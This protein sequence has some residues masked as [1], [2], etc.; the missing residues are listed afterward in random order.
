MQHGTQAPFLCVSYLTKQIGAATTGLNR[1]NCFDCSDRVSSWQ[2]VKEP[3]Y[4]VVFYV[5]LFFVVW[6][7]KRKKVMQ[8]GFEINCFAWGYCKGWNNYRYVFEFGTFFD[9]FLIFLSR[10][11]FKLS[12]RMLDCSATQTVIKQPKS[13]FLYLGKLLKQQSCLFW[14]VEAIR[15]QNYWFW[16]FEGTLHYRAINETKKLAN[17]IGKRSRW[18]VPKT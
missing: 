13:A 1:A 17:K 18:Q 3:A 2:C 7:F 11:N 4:H 8:Q 5:I 10:L 9:K 15:L 12:R 14:P 16:P 6:G